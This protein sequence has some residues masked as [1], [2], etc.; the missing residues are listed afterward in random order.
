MSRDLADSTLERSAR[1]GI[2]TA[3]GKRHLVSRSSGR[4]WRQPIPIGRAIANTQIYIVD[5]EISGK[6][7]PMKLVPVGDGEL[8][9]G[10]MVW[11]G[12]TSTD[13]N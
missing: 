9:I 7:D 13:Q 4:V 8:L 2:C 11:H 10:G 5:L 12:V 1:C 3:H 6:N